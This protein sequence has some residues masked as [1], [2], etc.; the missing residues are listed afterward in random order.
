MLCSI[1]VGD[2]YHNLDL[3]A[4]SGGERRNGEEQ[5]STRSEGSKTT[6]I[7]L[8]KALISTEH[9]QIG[10]VCMCVCVY[11]VGRHMRMRLCGLSHT[12]C[13]IYYFKSTVTHISI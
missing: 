11:H 8:D 13:M 6:S 10:N 2:I 5:K 4:V 7:S 3:C 12:A 9:A 1:V